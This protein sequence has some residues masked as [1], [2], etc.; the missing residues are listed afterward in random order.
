MKKFLTLTLVILLTIT[1]LSV[2]CSAASSSEIAVY[3]NGERMMFDV[4][5]QIIDNRTMVPMRAIFEAL[6]AWVEWV[7]EEDEIEFFYYIFAELQ[8]HFEEYEEFLDS[9]ELINFEIF[10]WVNY[11]PIIIADDENADVAVALQI[12]SS[13]MLTITENAT[14]FRWIELDVP[15][16]IVNNRT[17]VPLRAIS[18]ALNAEVD[19]NGDSRTV[20]ITPP[21]GWIPPLPP[22]PPPVGA[23]DGGR[24]PDGTLELTIHYLGIGGAFQDDWPVFTRAAELTGTRLRGTIPGAAVDDQLVF[25]L[26]QVSRELAD[27]V[28]TN[29]DNF[30][31][32]AED[33]VFV[34]LNDLLPRYAPNIHRFFQENPDARRAATSSDGNIYHIPRFTGTNYAMGWFIR[35]DWLDQLGLPV[36][37]TVNEFEATLRAF[38]TLG[39]N[40]VPFFC[41]HQSI[42]SLVM[43]YGVRP[44]WQIQPNG[45]VTHARF[46]P[47][48][49]YAMENLARWYADGLIDPEI[50]TRGSTARDILFNDNRGGA[51]HD[52]IVSTSGFNYSPSVLS[53][54]PNFN[55]V[56]I[57]PPA[58]PFG[59]RAEH[60]SRALADHWGWG[61]STQNQFVRE[62]LEYFDF[63]FTEEGMLL[64]QFGV[65]GVHWNWG[66]LNGERAPIV[67]PAILYSGIDMNNA[68]WD[69]G[70][71]IWIGSRQD[72]RFEMQWM[73]PTA[74]TAVQLYLDG[75]YMLP[76]FPILSF[77]TAEI[78]RIAI[79][80]PAIENRMLEQEARWILSLD[81]V[82][83]ATW[84]AYVEDLRTLGITEVL[85]IF[86]AALE[87]YLAE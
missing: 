30:D 62:T 59:V 48:Y 66:Y 27:I 39:D 5:P 9:F 71:S 31:M 85:A 38:Q 57:S 74:T 2:A 51:T 82:N 37:T 1:S 34:P 12:G 63:W 49:R 53:R 33:G 54:N 13:A 67:A 52:W 83:D 45:M 79:L 26:M 60:T 56:A 19:W 7:D 47:Q 46:H 70:G 11:R 77:T 58:N 81:P 20:T 86:Q 15:P 40:I 21:Y 78:E 75:D 50:F 14:I 23:R 68:I 36:P 42:E 87:R 65:E 69:I 35:Q 24:R 84:N 18:E 44:G 29:R 55:L 16:Q 8:E 76:P 41:R 73:S 6:N 72:V 80:W 25:G 43:L 61:I 28:V 17:L 10:D 4:P 22:P 64:Y 32:F 3:L